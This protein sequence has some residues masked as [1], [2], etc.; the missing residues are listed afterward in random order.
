MNPTLILA[1]LRQ[2][3]TSPIRLVFLGTAF[4]FPLLFIAAAPGMGLSQIHDS[5]SFAL[6]FGVGMIGLDVSSGVLQLVL[7]R[8][9]TRTEYVLSRWFATAL[10]AATFSVLQG[11]IATLI[12]HW[13][14]GPVT[15]E[16]VAGMLLATVSSAFGASAVL[17]ALSTLAPGLADIGLFVLIMISTSVLQMTGSAMNQEWVTRAGALIGE[18]SNPTLEWN[19]LFGASMSWH[20][21]LAYTSTIALALAIGILMINRKELSYA[22]G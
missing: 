14:G 16:S 8:P 1:Y 4:F 18:S 7:A 13:R 22:S 10:G 2:R 6:I 9:V 11:A 12:L 21:I 20:E 15:L 3:L 19:R 17:M 5:L